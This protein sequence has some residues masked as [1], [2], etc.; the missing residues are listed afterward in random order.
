MTNFKKNIY[1]DQIAEFIK[2]KL[3]NGQLSPG[4]QIR[5]TQIASELSISR[6]PIREAMQVLIRE[7]LVEAQP[8]KIK[9][10]TALTAKEI[11]NS[12]FTGAVL[13]AA[14]VANSVNRYTEAE[15]DEL[16]KIII[17]M[18]KIADTNGLP[19]DL[20]PL[21]NAFH[22]VLFSKIDNDLIIELC[23]R[24]CQGISKFL[25]YKHW[26]KLFPAEKVYERHKL[27]ID[28]IETRDHHIIENTIREHYI[29]AGEKM[30]LYG[31]DIKRD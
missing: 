27:I 25:L 13:E 11:E 5:E 31:E 18:K 20:A 21:D 1:S 9:R 26:V 12:Y 8:Q 2:T 28:A 30:S 23:R 3:L 19:S 7:G 16:K 17:K 29:E 6:A 14:A 4:D 10:I 22:N 24:T 15:I